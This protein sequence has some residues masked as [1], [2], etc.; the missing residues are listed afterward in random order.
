MENVYVPYEG[1]D[2]VHGPLTVPEVYDIKG[3]DLYMEAEVILPRD[4]DH[5]QAAR[6]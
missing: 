6:V 4:I 2:D 3:Y 5:Q 1:Y